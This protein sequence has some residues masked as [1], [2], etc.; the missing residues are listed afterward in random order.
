MNN[1][2]VNKNRNIKVDKTTSNHNLI[3]ENDDDNFKPI[4]TIRV[5][6]RH[7]RNN[8]NINFIDNPNY[9]DNKIV[10]NSKELESKNIR[11]AY[12]SSLYTSKADL[13][14]S[15][16]KKNTTQTTETLETAVTLNT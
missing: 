5:G 7:N 9:N 10:S 2:P 8:P 15:N 14:K 4:T 1:N 11:N 13:F 6:S 3:I 12:G 16:R